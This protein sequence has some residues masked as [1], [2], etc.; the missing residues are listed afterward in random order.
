[1]ANTQVFSNS[2]SDLD[3]MG[4][5]GPYWTDTQKAVIISVDDSFDPKSSR[6]TNGGTNWSSSDIESGTARK[7]TA[8]FD[9]ETPGDEGTLVHVAWLDSTLGEARY[10]TVNVDDG[11]IGTVRTIISGLTVGTAEVLNRISITKTVGGNLLVA[12]ETQTEIECLRSVD[13][14]INWT[15]RADPYETATEEDW[16]LLYPANTADD[17]DVAGIFWD[18]SASEISIKM[19]DDSANTWTETSISTGMEADLSYIN[20][21][22]S[23]RHSD[24]HILLVAHS[25]YDSSGDDLTTW[26]LTVDSIASPIVTAK[27]NIFTNQ[28]ES[29]QVGLI[30]NQQNDDVYVGYLRGDGF[31]FNVVNLIYHKST[32]GMTNWGSEQAYSETPDDFRLCPGGRTVGDGGGRIQW[33]WFNDDTTDIWVNLVND[34][35]IP[36]ASV[37]INMQINIGDSWKDV[38]ALKI[39]IGDSWKP[40]TSIK[41]NI[42]DVWKTVFQ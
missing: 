31:W 2:S 30:I 17:N 7:I 34:I 37:G 5:W 27:T 4:M 26:D 15:D 10:C 39:N 18:R 23:V 21:D 9:Q 33:S 36:V 13:G 20:M 19:Y 14:G 42:G 8:W 35:E 38:D 24:N 29:A 28:A 16:L 22:A 1:M 12:L 3:L 25:D 41:Q 6:T 11:T 32:N 40:V